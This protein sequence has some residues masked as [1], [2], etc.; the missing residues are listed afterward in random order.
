MPNPSKEQIVSMHFVQKTVVEDAVS[1]IVWSQ[2]GRDAIGFLLLGSSK[3]IAQDV[4]GAEASENAM[5]LDR[6]FEEE[7]EDGVSSFSSVIKAWYAQ[8]LRS[9]GVVPP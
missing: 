8:G 5:G 4:D 9:L 6:S 3:H 1:A 2:H 7:H